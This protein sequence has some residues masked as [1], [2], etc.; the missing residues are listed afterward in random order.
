MQKLSDDLSN[1]SHAGE[2]AIGEHIAEELLPPL[3]DRERATEIANRKLAKLEQGGLSAR[4][5]VQG[6]RS[7]RARREINYRYGYDD[8]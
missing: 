6:S 4:N 3:Y 1:S 8:E 7:R 2:K 5:I